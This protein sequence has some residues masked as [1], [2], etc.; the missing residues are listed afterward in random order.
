MVG[1]AVLVILSPGLMT[2]TEALLSLDLTSW[3]TGSFPA[4]TPV[5][6]VSTLRATVVST[7]LD[8]PTPRSNGAPTA[9]SLSSVTWMPVILHS[10][11]FS[12]RYL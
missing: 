1:S 4:A 5:L 12:T 10:P 7:V 2:S 9:P 3:P 11:V 6:V 8:S